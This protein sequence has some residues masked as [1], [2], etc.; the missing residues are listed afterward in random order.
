VTIDVPSDVIG[1]IEQILG[2]TNVLNELIEVLGDTYV[3]GNVYYDGTEFTYV[4]AAGDTHVIDLDITADN[5]LTQSDNNIQLGGELL[6]NTTISL[7]DYYLTVMGVRQ[8]TRFNSNGGLTQRGTDINQFNGE[9][10]I[11]LS[12][13]G[14][15]VLTLQTYAGGTVQIFAG[16]DSDAL[17]IGTHATTDSAP[18]KFNTSIG[19]NALSTE[20]ARITGEGNMGIATNDPTERLDIGSGNMR[21]RDINTNVGDADDRIVVADEDGVLKSLKA[22]MPKFFYMPSII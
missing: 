11:E 15:N 2:D 9:A 3:G 7:E 16:Q 21:I 13:P 4:D 1:N 22:A 14:N 18:I 5:G 12:S 8:E 17:T 19:N 6:K 10:S 20:K